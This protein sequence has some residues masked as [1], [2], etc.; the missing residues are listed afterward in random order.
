MSVEVS[1]PC[2]PVAASTASVS[3]ARAARAEAA[4][5]QAAN[6]HTAIN[7]ACPWSGDRVSADAV[8]VY[9]GQIVGFCNPGCRDKFDAATSHF[10]ACAPGVSLMQAGFQRLAYYNAWFNARLYAAAAT[11]PKAE[12]TR[13]RGAVFGSILGTLNHI[14]VWDITW[15]QRIARD[16]EHL[17]AL[18]PFTALAAPVAHDQILH[19][20]LD[21]L[22]A[23]RSQID[24]WICAF[25]D[26]TRDTDYAG[27][28][29]YQTQNG[30]VYARSFAGVLQHVFNHQTHHRGQVTALLS[31]AGVDAGVTDLLMTLTDADAL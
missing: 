14:M 10:D 7:D 21:D 1:R 13:D 28:L 16:A 5:P 20:D 8:T 3:P 23:A 2:A 18:A 6:A 11:L 17:A 25:V 31:Q 29:R 12:L 4:V 27:V 15:M 22:L 24:G 30:D 26:E 19:A 9:N